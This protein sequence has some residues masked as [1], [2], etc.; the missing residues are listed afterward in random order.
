MSD[1]TFFIVFTSPAMLALFFMGRNLWL[2]NRLTAL[3]TDDMLRVKMP[4]SHMVL[5]FWV[6]DVRRFM[7]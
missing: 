3:S 6:W 1:W 2:F 5:K 7:E 4:W